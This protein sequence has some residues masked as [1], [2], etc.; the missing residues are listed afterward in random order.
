MYESNEIKNRAEQFDTEI[1]LK[2]KI[3][4]LEKELI[5]FAFEAHEIYNSKDISD[6]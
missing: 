3:N 5:D 6:I 2:Y 1:E 4:E